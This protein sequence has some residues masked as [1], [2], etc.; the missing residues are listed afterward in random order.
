MW[1]YSVDLRTRIVE[2]Y[3]AGGESFASLADRFRVSK[4]SARRYVIQW[5]NGG[6]LAPKPCKP[7][8]EPRISDEELALF[9]TWLSEDPSLTQNELASLYTEHTRRSI[10][11]QTVCRALARMGFT[12][13]KRVSGPSSRTGRT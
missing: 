1:S 13:K 5:Q 6:G 2:A 4:S 7:G 9:E 11:Q 3:N 8:P 10:S 12:Y